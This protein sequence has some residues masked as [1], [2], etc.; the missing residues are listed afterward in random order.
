M[1]GENGGLLV[2][3]FPSSSVLSNSCLSKSLERDFLLVFTEGECDD[4]FETLSCYVTEGS[5]QNTVSCDDMSG[6]Q[7]LV[8]SSCYR[9]SVPPPCCPALLLGIA[10]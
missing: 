4:L 6:L 5:G 9:V 2:S 3:G 10:A 7:V 8:P 1:A